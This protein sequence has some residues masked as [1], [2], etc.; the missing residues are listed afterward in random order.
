[1][2][3]GRE[4][5]TRV[6]LGALFTAFL[7]V[8]LCGFG[9]GLVWARRITVEQRQWISDEEFTE[10]LSLCQFLPGPNV[11]GIAVCVG[12]KLRGS[13]GALA[14][15]SGF[16]LIPWVIGFPL[17]LLYLRYVHLALF[18]NILGGISA[19]AAG[20]LVAAGIKMLIP[21]RTRPQVLV[22]AAFAFAGMAFTNLPLLVVLFGVTLLSIAARKFET[23]SAQ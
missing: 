20:L 8:S 9:G 22:F 5:A 18:Q 3:G 14:A 15:T 13:I 1:M 19:V 17:G 21:H 4:F 10:T 12:T 2:T 11:V 23:A 7:K 16:V 6:S